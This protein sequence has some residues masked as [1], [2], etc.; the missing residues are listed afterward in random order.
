LV[1]AAAL[2]VGG[3][4]GGDGS[5]TS[6]GLPPGKAA[7]PGVPTGG[8]QSIQTW[9]LEASDRERAAATGIVRTYLDARAAGKWRRACALLASKPRREQ[10]R[11]GAPSCARAMAS[12]A[13]RAAP[14]VLREEAQME[15]LSFRV[16][17]SGAFLIYRRDDGVW[18]TALM[19]EGGGWRVFSVTP[20][21]LD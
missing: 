16:A 5:T 21:Q 9:G 2:L 1:V 12:F 4:G 10:T 20:E 11:F 18:A 3:C 17:R 19:R 6:V 13:A 7:A 14:Q 15:V 8:D